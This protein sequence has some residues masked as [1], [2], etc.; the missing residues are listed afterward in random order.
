MTRAEVLSQILHHK[1]VAVIRLEDSTHT[2]QVVKAI[3]DGGIRC[4]EITLTNPDALQY[5]KES[6]SVLPDDAIM[7]AG[8][9]INVKQVHQAVSAGAQ[10]IVSPVLKKEIIDAAHDLDVPVLLGAFSPTEIQQAWEWGADIVKVFPADILGMNY[11]KSV[12]APLPHLRI[13]PTG[14]VTLTNGKDW[15]NAGASAVGLGSALLDKKAIANQ[16]FSQITKNAEVI[17]S[18]INGKY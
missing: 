12:K 11:F 1:A 10:F 17:I 4:M 14:G 15:L 2:T 5:I 18:K 16:D 3:Y 6:I 13:M 8:S 7:G 9:V